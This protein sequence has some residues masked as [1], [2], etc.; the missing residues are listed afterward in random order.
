MVRDTDTGLR[1]LRDQL[2]CTSW[3]SL[4]QRLDLT[5]SRLRLLRSRPLDQWPYADLQRWARLVGTSVPSLLGEPDPSQSLRQECHRLQQ[6]LA[7]GADRQREQWE[8]AALAQLEPWLLNWPRA[9]QAAQANPQL[10]ARNI[11]ALVRPLDQVLAN[12]GIEVLGQVG[13]LLAYDPTWQCCQ[14][15]EPPVGTEVKV[16][17]P[18]YRWRGRC[19]HRVEVLG[20]GLDSRV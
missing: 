7:Q 2:G 6:Q 9:V 5:P 8:A 3:A 12:W 11:L 19:L 10:P 20:I 15:M 4:A 18:G 14:G 13:E 16:Q 17:R 1:A